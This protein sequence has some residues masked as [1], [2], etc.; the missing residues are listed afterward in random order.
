[1]RR[2]VLLPTPL[3]P[4]ITEILPFGEAAGESVE[5]APVAEGEPHAD[6]LDVRLSRDPMLGRDLRHRSPH[7]D[8]H[9]FIAV[10][11]GAVNAPAARPQRAATPRVPRAWRSRPRAAARRLVIARAGAALRSLQSDEVATGHALDIGRAAQPDRGLRAALGLRKNGPREAASGASGSAHRCSARARCA[12][13][14]GA[15]RSRSR[16]CPRG[17]ARAR[18]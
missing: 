7:P 12:P 8:P 15:P 10:V 9:G 11:A 5:D 2:S 13:R 18:A 16:R 17:A 4:R 1:M 3:A 14:P 6:H